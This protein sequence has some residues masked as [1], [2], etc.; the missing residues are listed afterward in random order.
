MAAEGCREDGIGFAGV[1][2]AWVTL[3][4]LAHGLRI[5]EHYEVA[6]ARDLKRESVP[7]TVLAFVEQPQGV[8]REAEQLP[9]GR[10]AGPLGK[11]R[12]G[13]GNRVGHQAT[14]NWAALITSRSRAASIH[15]RVTYQNLLLLP[16]LLR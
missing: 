12:Q 9:P 2:N 8:T 14:S 4:Y 10:G 1:E 16:E 7:E 13:G 6:V 5:R 15:E 3:E 11:C